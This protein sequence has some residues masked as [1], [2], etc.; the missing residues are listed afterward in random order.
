MAYILGRKGFRR[1]EL[2]VDP[3]VLIPRP[4]TEHVVEAALGLP[5]GARVVDVGTGSGAI[6]LAL[7]DE[8]PDLRVVGTESSAGAL[9]VARANAARLDLDVELLEGDLLEPV[10]GP[11][12][13]VVSN[14][15]YVPDGA[16]LAPE[17][18]YEPVEALYAGH[19]GLEVYRRLVPALREVAFVALEV[20]MGRASDVAALLVGYDDRDHPRSRRHRPRRGGPSMTFDECIAG[21]GVVV[22]PA[23]TVYGLA[24]DPTNEA[25]VARLY[26]LKGRAADKPAAVMFFD[27]VQALAALPELT[28]RTRALMARLLPGAVTLLVPSERFPLAGGAG[29]LGL[30][31]PDIPPL[32]SLPVLQS[33]A[34][35]AGGPDARRLEDVPEAIRRGADLVLDG[36]ELPGTPSTV[37]DL[38]GYERGGEWRILRAGAVPEAVVRSL[39]H[40]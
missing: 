12:D 23:D 3:R 14:P 38:R 17:L 9:A 7:A 19:E 27:R 34:N 2:A 21:G 33:S 4:E 8:R 30:R 28:A 5:A 35:V 6:A 20:G 37:V 31:V 10:T 36:G 24:C 1:L 18:A 25:A 13:A 16:R 26:E 32:G 29:T 39:A 22:F 15:P 40:D 11:V